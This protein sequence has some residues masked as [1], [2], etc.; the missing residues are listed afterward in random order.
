MTRADADA[1]VRPGPRAASRHAPVLEL[2][3]VQ[4]EPEDA[5]ART[6]VVLFAASTRWIS[7]ARQAAAFA[8][9]GFAVEAV[10]PS[11]HP[12]EEMEFVRR[13]HLLDAMDPAGSLR[14]AI[15]FC[16]P[17]LIAPGDERIVARLHEL[18]AAGQAAADPGSERLCA[19]IARSL[20]APERFDV[21]LSRPRF[22]ELAGE[23]GVRR[24]ETVQ[25]QGV[26]DLVRRLDDF[27]FPAV[28]KTDLSWGGEGVVVVRDVVE[29]VRAYRRLSNRPSPLVTLKH[30][31]MEQDLHF[32]ADAVQGPAPVVSL[33]RYVEGRP[34][35]AAAACWR[36]ELLSL[37]CVE[38]VRTTKAKG[39][40]SVVTTLAHPEMHE[41][42][43]RMVRRLGLSGLCGFDFLIDGEG[44]AWLLEL[45][46]R[47]TPTCHLPG[48]EGIDPASALCAR[49]GGR[50]KPARRPQAAGELIALFP[51]E[52][53]R[54]PRSE[55]LASAR[56]D[57]PSRHPTLVKLGLQTVAK[58]RWR[59][60]YRRL[61][62]RLRGEAG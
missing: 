60:L 14:R 49:L 56:H 9:A 62:A 55:A 23:E 20:G 5:P 22:M 15:E 42:A 45:N 36:G 58:A 51:Q 43:R 59:R 35:N 34:A 27:G 1:V 57:L 33:Q 47:A 30:L 61:M 24:P 32:A 53:M 12:L 16:D 19:T 50:G 54:D 44:A 31:V 11:G 10:C 37:L 38:A 8:E 7:S 21:I 25:L 40:A 46:P 3:G 17:D 29:A 41:T 4:P 6:P 28:L 26:E 2:V 13:R 39:H 48:A 18:H 52:M